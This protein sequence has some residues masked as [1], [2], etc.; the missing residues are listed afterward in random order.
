MAEL[1]EREK[2][3]ISYPKL[4]EAISIGDYKKQ[5]SDIEQKREDNM[6]KKELKAANAAKGKEKAIETSKENIQYFILTV[7]QGKKW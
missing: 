6:N 7:T 2:L 4:A 5:Q 1:D 3:K